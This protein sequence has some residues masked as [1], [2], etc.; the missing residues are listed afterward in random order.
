MI[1]TTY[2]LNPKSIEYYIIAVIGMGNGEIYTHA[3]YPVLYRILFEEIEW[4]ERKRIE[5]SHIIFSEDFKDQVDIKI[6]NLIRNKIIKEQDG[7]FKLTDVGEIL[8]PIIEDTLKENEVYDIY[9]HIKNEMNIGD[10]KRVA[11]KFQYMYPTKT[12]ILYG[13]KKIPNYVLEW[14]DKNEGSTDR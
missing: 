3:L 5:G 2:K 7:V 1:R 6:A 14:G 10:I 8:Y 13:K 12:Y 9:E 4:S 11:L